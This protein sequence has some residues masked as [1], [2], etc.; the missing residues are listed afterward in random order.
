MFSRKI[1]MDNAAC[2]RRNLQLTHNV[3]FLKIFSKIMG[4]SPSW[5]FRNVTTNDRNVELENVVKSVLGKK[6]EY[7]VSIMSIN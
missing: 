4:P 7:L 3:Q 1:A 5:D 6:V 2:M